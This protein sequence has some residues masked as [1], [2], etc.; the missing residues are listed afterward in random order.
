M[1]NKLNIIEDLEHL[2]K[3]FYRR[4]TREVAID[5]LGKYICHFISKEQVLIA[6]IVETEA[7]LGEID[8]AC[9]AYVGRTKRTSAFWKGA[10]YSYVYT[11]Y[12][13][14]CCFNTIT[15]PLAPNHLGGVLIRAA[16]PIFG[17]K[18]MK[19]NR[20]MAN[21]K[22]LMNGCGKLCQALQIGLQHNKLPLNRGELTIRVP[23]IAEKDN[24]QVTISPRI[25]ISKA[26]YWEL[27]YFITNNP[28]V[29]KGKITHF[30]ALNKNKKLK[31][32]MFYTK[33]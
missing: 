28:Y 31:S 19:K 1:N 2:S 25:G 17:I 18:T 5:L 22:E 32:I 29:S 20:K 23:K 24:I 21:P 6:K 13:I 15:S 14:H 30:R 33:I 16:E 26:K 9:H 4:D 12:G 7:Y 3:D 10:G 8:P 11:I 27:R